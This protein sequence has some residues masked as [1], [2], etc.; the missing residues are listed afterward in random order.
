VYEIGFFQTLLRDLSLGL[1]LLRRNPGLTCVAV[2]SLALGIGANACIFTVV[3]ALF[4]H[5]LPVADP[6]SLYFVY[7]LDAHNPGYLLQ[8]SLTKCDAQPPYPGLHTP[9]IQ[10]GYS[11]S[12]HLAYTLG[13][14]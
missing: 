12:D 14:T 13:S 11:P 2:L 1:R 8:S 6:R 3:N 9:S 5:P 10:V 7:T 4:L